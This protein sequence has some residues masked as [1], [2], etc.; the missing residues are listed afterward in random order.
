M[1]SVL[2]FRMSVVYILRRMAQDTIVPLKDL[3][4]DWID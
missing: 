3:I 4:I 1:I 2:K